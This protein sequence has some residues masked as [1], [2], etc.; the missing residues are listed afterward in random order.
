MI[1][2]RKTSLPA[3]TWRIST[4]LLA[5]IC[6][7]LLSGIYFFGARWMDTVDGRL[8]SIETKVEGLPLLT[9]RVAVMW[10]RFYGGG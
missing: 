4:S 6:V 2:R 3:W 8:A 9:D 10:K 7:A 5:I 1:D